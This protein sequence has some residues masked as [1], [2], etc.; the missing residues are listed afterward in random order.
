MVVILL[1][2]IEADHLKSDSV[3]M[4][5][6]DRWQVHHRA[7]K[8]QMGRTPIHALTPTYTI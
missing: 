3:E 8:S 5:T 4:Y 1:S 2:T 7:T 6:L